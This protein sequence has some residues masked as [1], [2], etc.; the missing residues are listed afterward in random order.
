MSINLEPRE[1]SLRGLAETRDLLVGEKEKEIR[2]H[3]GIILDMR[4]HG[5]DP[6][7]IATI[8][9]QLEVAKQ[10][11]T[12][13]QK[14]HREEINRLGEQIKDI[15]TNPKNWISNLSPDKQATIQTATTAKGALEKEKG[16]Y[17]AKKTD[18]DDRERELKR[19]KIR[20]EEEETNP[21]KRGDEEGGGRNRGGSERDNDDSRRDGEN[22]RN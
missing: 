9:T 12:D 4:S 18:E 11:K 6:A 19:I 17:Q 10:A 3:T 2:R 14:L 1:K 16:S 5:A 22:K 8:Q 7:S 13:A 15:Q 20:R 21:R